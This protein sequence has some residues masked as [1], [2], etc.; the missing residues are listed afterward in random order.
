MVVSDF[1]TLR[2]DIVFRPLLA[3]QSP[4]AKIPFQTK[5]GGLARRSSGVGLVRGLHRRQRFKIVQD[6][7]PDPH[8]RHE[9]RAA[10][11]DAMPGCGDRHAA[12]A[13]DSSHVITYC[14][15]VL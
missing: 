10:E 2:G 8:R 9:V 13:L 4:T 6:V 11:D 7:V 14:K 3:R 5:E 15:S 12:G 1:W